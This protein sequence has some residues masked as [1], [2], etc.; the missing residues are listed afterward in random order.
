M[1]GK[2]SHSRCPPPPAPRGG[3]D[4]RVWVGGPWTGTHRE[5]NATQPAWLMALEPVPRPV[6]GRTRIPCTLTLPREAAGA[7]RVLHARDPSVGC[8]GACVLRGPPVVGL[9]TAL[10][11]C[12]HAPREARVTGSH[13]SDSISLARD[14]S[15]G[16]VYG[17]NCV[18]PETWTLNCD[19]PAP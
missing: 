17:L 8:L 9:L 10:P 2:G 1:V 13:L 5:I 6:S 18:S 15:K 3:G 16:R 19:S 11:M 4:A 14:L 7:G 12:P